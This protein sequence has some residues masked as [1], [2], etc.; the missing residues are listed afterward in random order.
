MLLNS[1]PFLLQ[2]VVVLEP[3]AWDRSAKCTMFHEAPSAQGPAARRCLAGIPAVLRQCASR[4]SLPSPQ[5][6]SIPSSH[7]MS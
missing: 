5:H 7:V 4:L 2:D 1:E 3:A 6:A